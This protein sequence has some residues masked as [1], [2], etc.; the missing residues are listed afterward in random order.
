MK[1][2]QNTYLISLFLILLFCTG[3]SENP[4]ITSETIEKKF[5]PNMPLG[6]I[7]T[8][9][10]RGLIISIDEAHFFDDCDWNLKESSLDTLNLIAEILKDLPNFCVIEDHIQ[11]RICS[12]KLEN[13]ELSMMRSASIVE[14]L[15]KCRSV[16]QEQLFDIGYGEFM[17]FR[18]NVNPEIKGIDNRV[19]FVI[20]DYKAKR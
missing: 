11:N 12:D 17:P 15:V 3:F 13:W 5:K 4:S 7:Y 16:S 19:D 20:I 8:I 18:G 2:L 10:P 14:Y 1:N 6:T 9:V